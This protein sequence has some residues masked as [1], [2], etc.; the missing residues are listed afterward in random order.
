MLK[1]KSCFEN[2]KIH[3]S[4]P[5]RYFLHIL[6]FVYIFGGWIFISHY[7]DYYFKGIISSLLSLIIIIFINIII[8]NFSTYYIKEA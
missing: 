8:I 3:V 4:K 1:G 5:V 2:Y 7:L 6:N